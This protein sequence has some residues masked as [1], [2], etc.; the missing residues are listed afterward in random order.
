MK[1]REFVLALG[2]A[3]ALPFGARAQQ[4]GTLPV[5]GFLN[6]AGQDQ[7]VA[8]L[9]AFQQGLAESG[10]VEGRNVLIEYRWAAGQYQL[11][12]AMAADL[13][14]R[15]VT[16]IAATGDS[17]ALAA[18]AATATIPIVFS[19]GNDPINLGLVASLN[20]PG[21]NVTGVTNLNVEIT[22]KRLELMHEVMPSAATIALL[23]N[24]TGRN[25]GPVSEEMHDA[26]RKLGLQLRVV[27]ASSE[28]EF[29]GIFADLVRSQAKALVI[30]ADAFFNNQSE[31]LGALS[32]RHA[33]PAVF[34][35]R[36]FALAGG[37]IA[38]GVDLTEPARWMGVY[39]GRI[40]K[41]EKPADLAVQQSRKVELFVNLKTAK[42]LGVTVPLPL[43]GRAD[44]VME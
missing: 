17:A 43:L 7:F 27:Q 3:A 6:I 30:G 21:G 34:Q 9:R 19:G 38:Y 24:P 39:A 22:A 18:K 42:A 29:E 26:A 41:G 44:E 31:R 8:R 25:A 32:L 2:G 33:L 28:P 12:P 11:L 37:L 15:G 36:T 20:R 13:V 1:R 16:V 40:L 4:R 14:R 35:T 5:I 10:Y 23:I